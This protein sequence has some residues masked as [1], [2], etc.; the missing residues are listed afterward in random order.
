MLRHISITLLALLA[1]SGAFA[2]GTVELL[3]AAA[4]DLVAD[5]LTAPLGM[6]ARAVPREPVAVSW[7]LPA[8]RQLDPR[9]APF[10]ATSK[11]FQ[12]EVGAGELARGVLLTVTGAGAVVRVN[13]TAASRA[14]AITADHLAIEPSALLLIDARGRRFSGGSGMRQVASAAQL[15][16][17]GVPFAPG[18]TAFRIA[19]QLGAGT[20]TLQAPGLTG[21]LR[22]QIH[23]LDAAS[24]I[25]LALTTSAS[26]YLHGQELVVEAR[27]ADGGAPMAGRLEG[28]VASPAG[29]TWPLAF[30]AA[31]KGLY[32]A[33]LVLDAREAPAPGLWQVHAS[34]R[35]AMVRR[36]AHTAF[37]CA[38]PAAR[39][40]GRA[41]PAADG[42]VGVSLGLEVAAASR[43]E[44][45]GVLFATAA[46]GELRPVAVGASAA[47]LEPGAGSLELRFTDALGEG[48]SAP[49]EVRDLRLVDQGTMGVLHRQ[50]RGLTIAR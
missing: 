49:F 19:E 50:A 21:E 47:W 11:E 24:A 18:T 12:V 37:A 1:A 30:A 20:F 46:D 2:Q 41:T 40:D 3:P 33:T 42:D 10:V 13:P 23:V 14:A 5:T 16:Q 8:D 25:E 48:F 6:K 9:P 31:G 4:G 36:D 29:R 7:P 28:F 45:R 15:Q 17:A 22:Y 39:L 38:V 32:H 34:A 26:D 44:V 43:Y 35:G 27:L